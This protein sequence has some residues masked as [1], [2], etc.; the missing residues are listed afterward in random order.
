MWGAGAGGGSWIRVAAEQMTEWQRR[1]DDDGV[2]IGDMLF[3][4]PHTRTHA[5]K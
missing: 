2:Y 5:K 1:E 4:Y 3:I